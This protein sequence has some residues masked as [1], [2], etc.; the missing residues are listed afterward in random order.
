MNVNLYG[1]GREISYDPGYGWAHHRTG[2]AHATVAHNLVAVDEKN[3]PLAPA[4]SGGSLQ[5][6]CQSPGVRVVSADDPAA[7]AAQGVTRYRRTLAL[8][9]LSPG[10]SYLL[11][12]FD[13]NGGRQHDLSHHFAGSLSTTE[14]ITLG[15]PQSRGSLAGPQ[16][17][18]WKLIQPSGWIAGQQKPFYW[19]P[20]PENGYGFL[21]NVRQ[22]TLQASAPR[23]VWKVGQ[24]SRYRPPDPISPGSAASGAARSLIAGWSVYRRE[25]PGPLAAMQAVAAAEGDYLLLA[26]LAKSPDGGI[27]ALQVDG[28]PQGEPFNAFSPVEYAADLVSFGRVYLAA[29]VHE[30]H[31]ESPAKDPESGGYGLRMKYFALDRPES[32]DRA[33]EGREEGV[34]LSLLPPPR[35][36]IVT[37]KAKGLDGSRR[38]TTC[39]SAA[40]APICKAASSRWWSPSSRRRKRPA[41]PRSR[42]RSRPRPAGAIRVDSARGRADYFFDFPLSAEMG[43]VSLAEAG[44]AIRF[45]GHFGAVLTRCGK[46]FE[47]LLSSARHLVF[48]DLE[49]ATEQAAHAGKV[50]SV[51]YEK[52]LVTVDAA[53]PPALAG[54]ERLVYFSSAAYSHNAP[55]WS[56]AAPCP[57]AA[58]S[59]SAASLPLARPRLPTSR[60]TGCSPTACPWIASTFG[61]VSRSH[62][63]DGK[64]IRNV[65]TGQL[66]R[67]RE[68]PNLDS[69]L[70]VQ[71]D[72]GLR[73]GDAFELL[74]LQAGDAFTM[75]ALVALLQRSPRQWLLDSNV[76]VKLALPGRRWP[77]G[78]DGSL[79][80]IQSEPR[81]G[82]G[83]RW[84]LYP[85]Q[86][87]P[88]GRWR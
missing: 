16:Y 58:S 12:I 9:D 74:D 10:R 29:G 57:A 76:R 23:F 37:A 49:I 69:S 53:L 56:A 8:V 39:W 43:T 70:I 68:R 44:V 73:P 65:R 31:F 72:P 5:H 81:P 33:E 45:A 51:D 47:V 11:D 3:Q 88:H 4:G 84:L 14:G 77:C 28:R 60:P 40:A 13:V 54:G 38:P 35:S 62:Y 78:S 64:A 59:T 66:G 20:P 32:L 30:L 48:A 61:H 1:L 52:G 26:S 55:I 87:A 18:W 21:Y 22:T 25:K 63:F 86:R 80:P 34:A 17:E 67:N 50:L 2:W 41:W 79:C 71:L 36:R 46:P 82:G 15:L 7:Y 6:F 27:I 83:R 85:A 75:P 19:N 42:P 24:R